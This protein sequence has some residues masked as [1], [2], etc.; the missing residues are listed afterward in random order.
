MNQSNV[1]GRSIIAGVFRDP[2]QGERALADLK[3]AGFTRAEISEVNAESS[4]SEQSAGE[5]ATRESKAA[6][7]GAGAALSGESFFRAHDS[8]TSSFA[9]ELIGL[10]FSKRDAHDLVDGMLKGGALV[11]ADAGTRSDEA[12]RIF[13][14]Y[15]GDVRTAGADVREGAGYTR[16]G[17]DDQQL[18]LREEQLQVNKQR[19]AHGEVRLR[20][21]VVTE[22]QTMSVPVSR[23]ELVVERHPVSGEEALGDETG[24]RI[25]DREEMRIPL[26]REK[27]DV[28][29]RTVPTEEVSVGK[30]EVQETQQVS[31]TVQR[32]KLKIDD[33]TGTVTEKDGNRR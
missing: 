11:S 20:K 13:S 6:K 19:V 10:G 17:E 8:S 29:K 3:S 25:G 14:R 27:V 7:S 30:R 24:G 15:K 5:Y 18:R 26:S 32:E 16:K 33:P 28:T 9:D 1:S 23:E 4:T 22:D 12:M 21:E 2:E 31:D